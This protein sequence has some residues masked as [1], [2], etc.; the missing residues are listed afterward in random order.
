MINQ[1][2]K[3]VKIDNSTYILLLI[4]FLAGYFEY[5]YL[6]LI[7][8]FIHELG[9]VFFAYLVKIKVSD[10]IIYPF[11]GITHFN[12]DLNVNSN[13]ELI[14][15]FGGIIFQLLFF[16]L[17]LFLYHNM[18]ITKHVFILIKKINIKLIS[19]NFLPI[20]PLDGGRLVNL[21]LDKIL[22]YRLSNKISII[23]S[24]VFTFIFIILNRTLLSLILSIFL[25]KCIIIEFKKSKYKYN[26]FLLERHINDYNFKHIRF[27][28]NRNN[29]RRDYYHYINSINEKDYLKKIFN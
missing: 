11:G 8:I 29:F 25:I 21:F 10:I 15:L 13:K 24:I 5:M 7:I 1:L 12:E 16:F 9:H 14:S 19:F 17:I 22:P 3:I 4:S 2:K 6:L 23:I 26:Q 27:I 18:F 20:L 28:N